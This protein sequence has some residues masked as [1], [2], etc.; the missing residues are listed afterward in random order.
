VVQNGVVCVV[1]HVVG[2]HRGKGLP[3]HGKNSPLDEHQ[4]LLRQHSF[5]LGHV[6]PRCLL[7]DPDTNLLLDVLDCVPQLLHHS[8]PLE[9]VHIETLGLCARDEKGHHSGCTVIVLQPLI[10]AYKECEDGN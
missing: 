2:N 4:L 9:G 7:E 6:T 3:L 10:Q 1:L 8:L 5:H